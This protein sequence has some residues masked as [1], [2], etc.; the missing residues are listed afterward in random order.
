[1][2]RFRHKYKERCGPINPTKEEKNMLPQKQLEEI[3]RRRSELATA[4]HFCGLT[5]KRTI[6]EGRKEEGAG[7]K[8]FLQKCEWDRKLYKDLEEAI[9]SLEITEDEICYQDIILTSQ[10]KTEEIVCLLAQYVVDLLDILL[11]AK[12]RIAGLEQEVEGFLNYVY[13]I[14]EAD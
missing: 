2:W 8:V 14:K 6:E 12:L 4:A 1:M 9:M 7:V 10:S 13:D 11:N 5:L 3:K